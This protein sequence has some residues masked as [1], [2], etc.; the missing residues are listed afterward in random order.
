M[1]EIDGQN[2]RIEY[3]QWTVFRTNALTSVVSVAISCWAVVDQFEVF[4][5]KITA[6]HTKN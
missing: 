4:N 5:Y 1:A 6:L 3:T 2:I